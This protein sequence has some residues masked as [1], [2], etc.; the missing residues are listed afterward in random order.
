MAFPTTLD[1]LSTTRASTGSDKLKAPDHLVH[2][3]AEDTLVEALQAKIGID[4]SAVVTSL[5]YIIK[6][7]NSIN[8]GHL[9]SYLSAPDG[10]PVYSLNIDNAGSVGIGT[11]SP[12]S[13]L[14]VYSADPVL[15]LESSNDI[16]LLPE[17]TYGA[18]LKYVSAGTVTNYGEI[19]IAKN[20]TTSGNTGGYMAFYKKQTGVVRTEAM[21]LDPDG[22]FGIN[23]TVP[24]AMLDINSDIL[25]LRTAKTPATAGST[26]NQG[27]FCWDSDYMYMCVATNTWKKIQIATW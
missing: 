20:N 8:P 14:H 6:S 16:S 15:N 22:K 9:H 24:T 23:T 11:Q 4:D 5:D 25:R 2:H 21:R 1:D 19:H 17:V 7:A 10:S 3:T 13:K 18:R 12:S 26:G 27:D